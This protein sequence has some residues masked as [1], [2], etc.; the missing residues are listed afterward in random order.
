MSIIYRCDKC[1]AE[2]YEQNSITTIKLE[3]S[4]GSYNDSIYVASDICFNCMKKL[5]DWLT[6]DPKAMRG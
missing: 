3:S 1:H 5:R 2:S 6:P 4:T